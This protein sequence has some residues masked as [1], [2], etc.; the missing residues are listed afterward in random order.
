[1]VPGLGWIVLCLQEFDGENGGVFPGI[2]V[3]NQMKGMNFLV[4]GLIKKVK[5]DD[6]KFP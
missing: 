4:K 3:T 1:M 2:S 6:W 5:S